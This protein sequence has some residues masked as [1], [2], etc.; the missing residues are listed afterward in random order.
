VDTA[1]R[2]AFLI[3]AGAQLLEASL[4]RADALRRVAELVVPEFGELCLINLMQPDGTLRRAA[5]VIHPLG[6]R[7]AEQ[8]LWDLPPSPRSPAY[9][10]LASGQ[11]EILPPLSVADLV[12]VT[13]DPSRA[14][15]IAGLNLA[16]TL[17]VPLRARGRTVGTLSVSSTD[18][19]RYT[20]TEVD[21]LGQLAGLAGLAVDTA[22]LYTSEREAKEAANRARAHAAELQRDL[23]RQRDRLQFLAEASLVLDAPMSQLGRLQRLADLVV[24]RVAD[25]CAVH[26]VRG[27][28][29]EQV[30]VAHADPA[31]VALVAELQRDYPR[32]PDAPSE[33]INVARTGT[34]QFTPVITD[35]MLVAAARDARHL[36]LLRQLKMTSGIVVPLIVRGRSIGALTLV[37]SESGVKYTEAD[38]AF[39]QDLAGRAAIALDNAKLY[40]EQRSIA[41][42]LQA[43]LLPYELPQIPGMRTGASYVAQGHA[44][45]VGGDFYDVFATGN[46]GVWSLLIGDVCGKGAP[47]AALTA[48]VRHTVRAEANHPQSPQQVLRRLN[49]AIMRQLGPAETR[50]CT[51]IYGELDVTAGTHVDVTLT[52]GGHLPSR[53]LHQDGRVD[54][55]PAGGT[56]LGVSLDPAVA[57]ARTRLLPGDSLVLFTDGVTEARG[58]AGFYGTCRLDALLAASAGW[59][60]QAL[61]DRVTGEVVEFQSGAPRDDIAVLV[62]QAR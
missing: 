44:S 46:T 45:E 17:V 25:W 28:Q 1:G 58:P 21:L 36:D 19:D 5:V 35:A 7:T 20:Q 26:L 9:R 13:E 10:V 18:P 54:T 11:P 29:V 38:L 51:A 47:A 2:S 62:L 16:S 48:L 55:L 61:A 41:A 52:S 32:D 59:P 33:P 37:S 57:V 27:G 4:E 42:T 39:A 23:E 60:A 24:R 30:T 53:V 31:K 8:A 49:A 40:D 6:D 14:T 22:A 34:P 3:R 12:Q 43:A 50:F 56:A 15:A